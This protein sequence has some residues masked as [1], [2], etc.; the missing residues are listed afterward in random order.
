MEIEN[1]SLRIDETPLNALISSKL[2]K[3]T[4]LQELKVVMD[5]GEVSLEGKY[6][7]VMFPIK[8]KV[9][10]HIELSSNNIAVNFKDFK[11]QG[12]PAALFKNMLIEFIS[13]QTG[14]IDGISTGDNG[15]IIMPEVMLKKEGISLGGNLKKIE[16]LKGS[17]RITAGS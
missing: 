9:L 11:I 17:I 1:L 16:C 2:P 6:F 13:D 3:G 14:D 5:E 15:I 12:M 10:L 4:N 7:A 8:F